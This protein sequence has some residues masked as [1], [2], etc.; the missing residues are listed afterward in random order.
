MS[1]RALLV[2]LGPYALAPFAL[3]PLDLRAQAATGGPPPVEVAA[4]GPREPVELGAAF[5]LVVRRSWSAAD[6]EAPWSDAALAPL[7]VRLGSRDRRVREGRIEET[8]RF[9]A[10][11]FALDP[12]ELPELGLRID[13]RSVLPAE[14]GPPEA[15]PGPFDPPFPWRTVLRIGAVVVAACLVAWLVGRWLLRPRPR[16]EAPAPPPI[17]PHDRALA[18]LA[19]LRHGDP[20]GPEALQRFYVEA[21]S[22]VRDYVEDRFHVRA[23]EMTTEEF[24]AS[25]D[26]ARVLEAAHRGL[27][28]DFL[29]R[30]DLVKFARAASTREERDRLL[31]SAERLVQE[32]RIDLA[33]ERSMSASGA[34]P[35]RRE[36]SA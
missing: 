27:L 31:R 23:P 17:P 18:R 24:L 35:V 6:A 30:C 20:E 2:A 7:V 11:A 28:S 14:P 21:S 32:T 19:A 12:I 29:S 3:A 9:E 36:A 15:P 5:P 8:L 1:V 34:P 4:E 10:R 25:R 16:A 26:T 22:I 13:V 33:R